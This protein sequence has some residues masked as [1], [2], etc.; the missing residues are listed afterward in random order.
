MTDITYVDTYLC[1]GNIEHMQVP[2][3]DFIRGKVY[4]FIPASMINQICW[5]LHVIYNYW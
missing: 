3:T 1:V 4:D 5:F 2:Q